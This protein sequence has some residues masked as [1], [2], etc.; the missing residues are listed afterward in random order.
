MKHAKFRKPKPN[1]YTKESS[2]YST[3]SGSANKKRDY[4][5]QNVKKLKYRNPTILKFLPVLPLNLSFRS[6][7][8][9]PILSENILSFCIP[10]SAAADYVNDYQPDQ[11]QK[12]KDISF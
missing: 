10:E 2:S 5:G 4:R 3:C 9:L 6:C 7:I 11:C 12:E 1:R 8:T